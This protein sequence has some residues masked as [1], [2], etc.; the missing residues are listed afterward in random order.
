MHVLNVP[1]AA[2]LRPPPL[3]TPSEWA[4]QHRVLS[5]RAS[6]EPG[7]W[8]TD[9]TPY[10]REALDCLGV[11]HAAHTVVLMFGAQTGKSEAGNNWLG[12]T[13]ASEPGPTL[14]VQPTI[15]LAKRYSRQRLAPLIEE[16]PVLKALVAAPRSRDESN[17]LQIKEYVG[18][19][20]LL[21]GANNATGLRSM[22]I[23]YLFADE[24]DAWPATIAGEGDPL[25]LA[26]KRQSTFANRKT[27]ITSTPTVAGQSRIERLYLESDRREYYVPCPDCGAFQV[28]RWENLKWDEALDPRYAC[29]HCGTLIEEHHKAT[30]L[31][32]GEWRASGEFTGTA[33]FHLS[34]LYA[35]LGWVSWADLAREHR[36]AHALMKKGDSSQMMVFMNT[37][38]ARTWEPT[39]TK[40]IETHELERHCQPYPMGTVPVAG[41][42]ILTA[43]VDVQDDR[44]EVSVHAHDAE[45]R[46]YLVDHRVVEGNP[47]E[48]VTWEQLAQVLAQRWPRID[49][50]TFCE[51]H[52]TNVDSGGHYTEAVYRFCRGPRRMA[53]KGSSWEIEGVVGPVKRIEYTERG[54]SSKGY[55]LR[56]VNV[57]RLKHTLI[58]KLTLEPGAPG[59]MAF[60]SNVLEHVPDYFEQL[61]AE[62]L[63]E[64]TKGGATTYRWV[65]RREARNEALDCAIYSLAAAHTLALHH[66]SAQRWANLAQQQEKQLLDASAPPPPA[67]ATRVTPLPQAQPRTRRVGS[68]GMRNPWGR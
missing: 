6:A 3:L 31:P 58:E 55:K 23:R 36:S 11:H 42:V 32:A 43:G 54:R 30:M 63:V 53:V 64:V 18:G 10:L 24:V 34:T 47:G 52:Y 7:P 67:P 61:A 39:P 46:V 33:G 59:A 19:V 5:P 37:R 17:T 4:N 65:R 49:G 48:A 44:L 12:Y 57:N 28:L 13:I 41:G 2:G 15:E 16:S 25:G 56:L 26:L 45:S 21:T 51:I 35:P 50:K 27:L 68:F 9:R 1:W 38:L 20:L 62:K 14:A 8:R 40:M 22:P 29:E 66:L 60:P